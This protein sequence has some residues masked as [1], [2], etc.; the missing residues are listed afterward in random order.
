MTPKFS[1]EDA[2]RTNYP[3]IKLPE[4]AAQALFKDFPRDGYYEGQNYW[5]CYDIYDIN[6]IRFFSGNFGYD[7]KT[8]S[9]K[10][11][12]KLEDDIRKNHTS[13]S[14]EDIEYRKAKMEEFC[15]SIKK[16]IHDPAPVK[17]Y[18]SFIKNLS[19]QKNMNPEIKT[20]EIAASLC[21]E[22]IHSSTEEGKKQIQEKIQ[23]ELKKIYAK[24]SVRLDD[25]PEAKRKEKI[26][27]FAIND[28]QEKERIKEL[29]AAPDF[30]L[31]CEILDHIKN[32]T[33]FD[34]VS[35]NTYR[36]SKEQLSD[37]WIEMNYSMTSIFPP[38]TEKFREIY[39]TMGKNLIENCSYGETE[40]EK[41]ILENIG[42]KSFADF[43]R[44]KS[45]EFSKDMMKD[46]IKEFD[47]AV[48]SN[49][50]G[51]MNSSARKEYISQLKENMIEYRDY[52]DVKPVNK[53]LNT[54]SD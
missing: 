17:S 39:E 41:E 15:E 2:Y 34:F 18:P 27:E 44:N 9:Y 29:K 35:N 7:E 45:Y 26:Y 51:K 23:K 47:Y 52:L 42:N 54:R 19:E 16:G 37:I 20:S 11:L 25:I 40:T 33:I 8:Y 24:H 43:I 49:T 38:E 28:W 10:L 30:N 46:L 12:K 14:K 53:N 32:D 31:K 6:G 48:Y 13:F 36:M 21:N 4:G 22:Y 1:K 50:E 3:I 5:N